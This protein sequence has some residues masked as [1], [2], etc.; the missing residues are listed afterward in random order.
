MSQQPQGMSLQTTA[1]PS[2]DWTQVPNKELEALMDNSKGTE[3]AKE[4]ERDRQEALKKEEEHQKAE[5]EHLAQE[6][7][8]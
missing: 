6:Q 2:W 4:A 7:A 5:E 3:Q 1:A 8:E